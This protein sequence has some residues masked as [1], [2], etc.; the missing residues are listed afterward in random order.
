MITHCAL[1]ELIH[2]AQNIYLKI[3]VHICTNY[4]F[5]QSLRSS[6]YLSEFSEFSISETLINTSGD[7][8]AHFFKTLSLGFSNKYFIPYL[9]YNRYQF[10]IS[11]THS[12]S[13]VWMQKITYSYLHRL[14]IEFIFN[15]SLV[16]CPDINSRLSW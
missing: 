5:F 12:V 13:N 11:S 4:A 3:Y 15:F 16:E 7:K 8:K 14:L 1:N 9:K 2:W 10:Y 6:L